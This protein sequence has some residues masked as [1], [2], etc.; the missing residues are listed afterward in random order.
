M[1]VNYRNKKVFDRNELKQHD[2]NTFRGQDDQHTEFKRWESKYMSCKPFE[3]KA[4]VNE[5]LSVLMD[6][7]DE[8][9][10]DDFNYDMG[11]LSG[12]R[13]LARALKKFKG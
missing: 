4:D 7:R 3:N 12:Q 11:I 9:F 1:K 5:A 8:W 6:F 13:E 10:I 2:R